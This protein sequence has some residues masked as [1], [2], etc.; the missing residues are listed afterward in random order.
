MQTFY[1]RV[2]DILGT[3]ADIVQPAHA[4]RTDA[5]WFRG[6]SDPGL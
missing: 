2:A 6:S 3:L 4:R 1:T 5:L